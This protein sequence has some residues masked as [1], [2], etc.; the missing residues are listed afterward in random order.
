MEADVPKWLGLEFVGP[1]DD[2]MDLATLD[3][4]IT[5]DQDRGPHFVVLEP[6]MRRCVG[7]LFFR[8]IAN[9]R[10]GASSALTEGT[11][12]TL[13]LHRLLRLTSIATRRQDG[14]IE[15]VPGSSGRLLFGPYIGLMAG[16]YSLRCEIEV[17]GGARRRKAAVV[18]VVAGSRRLAYAECRG[19]PHSVINIPFAVPDECAPDGDAPGLVEF[20][21]E[22]LG[23]GQVIV[24]AVEL[25]FDKAMSRRGATMFSPARWLEPFRRDGG[26]SGGA[27]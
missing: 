6:E 22:C 9:A 3:R 13:G 27:P 18:E 14:S 12:R 15:S 2:T 5:P 1:F 26:A 10:P 4:A 16:T 20:L 8:K 23:K 7:V 25:E 21:V 11:F 17:R 19:R 24:H